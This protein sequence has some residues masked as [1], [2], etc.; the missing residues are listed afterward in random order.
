MARSRCARSAVRGS[1]E[2]EVTVSGIGWARSAVRR[3]G[4]GEGSVSGERW[5]SGER[6]VS[7]ERWV[8]GE[9]SVSGERGVRIGCAR[10]A[11]RRAV[12]NCLNG[13]GMVG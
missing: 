4:S 8:S 7:G 3:G 13:C 9:R 12:G 2:R 6:S 5:V 11:V 1:G 10:S